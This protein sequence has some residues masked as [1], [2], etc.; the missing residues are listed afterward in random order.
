MQ[1]GVEVTYH[2]MEPEA[3]VERRVQERVGRL[4]SIFGRIM[5]C[6]VVVD[7]PHQHQRKGNHYAV[8]IEVRVPGAEFSIDREPGDLNAHHDLLVALRDAF[9]ALERKLRRWKETHSGRPEAH[10][11]P[12]Q[13]RIAE[14]NAELDHGQI[15]TTDGRLV[16]FHR[17]SVLDADFDSLNENDPVELVV[18]QGIGE[19]GPHASTVRPISTQRFVDKSK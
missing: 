15:T 16:Y 13:G 10:A 19:G 11:E 2:G 14:L 12:L 17:N 18:D 9:D 4:E 3:H 1:T 6:R 5:S 7:A 8:R